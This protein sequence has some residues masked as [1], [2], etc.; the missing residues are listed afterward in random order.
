M[1]L[2]DH[3]KH[4]DCIVLCLLKHCKLWTY[5]SRLFENGSAVSTKGIYG[6]LS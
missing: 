1:L 5:E 4:G 2:R 3:K 6:K